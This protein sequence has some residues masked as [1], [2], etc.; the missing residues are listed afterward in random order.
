MAESLANTSRIEEVADDAKS[1]ASSELRLSYLDDV[2]LK[3]RFPNLKQ[4]TPAPARPAN[5]NTPLTITLPASS[6][7]PLRSITDILRELKTQPNETAAAPSTRFAGGEVAYT[8]SAIQAEADAF[9]SALADSNL[10][11]HPSPTPRPSALSNVDS[12]HDVAPAAP[13]SQ[14]PPAQHD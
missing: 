5:E 9:A 13:S 12:L 3:T 11:S 2:P 1:D 4:P 10:P 7:R 14:P 6:H 8:S